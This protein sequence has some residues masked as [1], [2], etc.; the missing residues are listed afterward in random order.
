MSVAEDTGSSPSVTVDS[1]GV[2]VGLG[3]TVGVGLVRTVDVAHTVDVIS[4]V[5]VVDV[6]SVVDVVGAVDGIGAVDMSTPGIVEVTSV[7]CKVT[8]S[9]A[10]GPRGAKVGVAVS[11]MLMMKGDKCILLLWWVGDW[12]KAGGSML[13]GLSPGDSKL[14][15]AQVL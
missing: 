2:C 10:V 6:I 8:V 5:D 11:S 12:M 7:V 14:K 9:V 1:I 4:V 3:V 15:T 13:R